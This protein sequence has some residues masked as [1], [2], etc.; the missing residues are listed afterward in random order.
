MLG[1]A[2]ADGS[3]FTGRKIRVADRP[4]WNIEP[5][6]EQPGSPLGDGAPTDFDL[7]SQAGNALERRVY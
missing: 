6:H 5:R 2:A 7:D 4:G 3:G 1:L